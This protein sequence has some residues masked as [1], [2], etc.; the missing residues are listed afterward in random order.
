MDP[1]PSLHN[2]TTLQQTP[3]HSPTTI[4]TPHLSITPIT[5][6]HPNLYRTTTTQDH[7]S[8][9]YNKEH[10]RIYNKEHSRTF[11]KSQAKSITHTHTHNYHKEEASRTFQNKQE[12]NILEDST[13]TTHNYPTTTDKIQ[14]PNQCYHYSTDTSQYTVHTKH[15]EQSYQPKALQTNRY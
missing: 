15:I 4:T 2:P 5:A 3:N 8:A 7:C 12:K 11:I 14:Y 6:S 9:I 13:S 1:S 10:S